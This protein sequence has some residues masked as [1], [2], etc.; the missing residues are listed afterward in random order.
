MEAFPYIVQGKNITVVVD[1]TPHTISAGHINYQKVKDAIVASD[2]A[3]V[4]EIIDPTEFIVNAGMGHVSIKGDVLYWKGV[5]MDN[6]LSKRLIAM[7]TDGFPVD[8][9]VAFMENLME[10][11]S[12]RAVNE[13][14]TFLEKGDLPITPDGHFLAYKKV[15]KDYLDLH[16]KTVPNKVVFTDEEL[17]EMPMKVGSKGEVTV[18]VVNDVTVIEMDRNMVDDDFNRTCSAG[19]HFCSQNYLGNFGRQ[20]DPVMILKINP[21]DVVSIPSDYNNTKGRA[22][23]Y[24]IIGEL[25][26][27]PSE[28]FTKPVQETANSGE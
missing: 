12:R 1:N 5:V 4:R 17:A 14:Y 27:N 9:M 13:L 7:V 21:R 6:S 22:C 11:P 8:P 18:N 19:L 15:G 3:T 2:W 23:R 16:S 20:D 25:G 24:T 28:A 10:N 26:V